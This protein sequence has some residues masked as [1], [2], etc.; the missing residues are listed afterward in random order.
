MRGAMDLP[1]GQLV[2]NPIPERD[3]IPEATLAPLIDRALRDAADR[4]IA[5]KAVTPFLLGRVH[6][7][8]RGRSLRANVSLVLNNAR[9]AAAIAGEIGAIRSGIR[10]GRSEAL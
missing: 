7:L 3:K 4:G 5:G 9:L 2:A 10:M 6:E 8:T 1:G